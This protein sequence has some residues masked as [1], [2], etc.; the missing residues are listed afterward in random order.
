MCSEPSHRQ[1]AR[2]LPPS[3]AALA[4]ALAS[5]TQHHHGCRHG[6]WEN[7][8]RVPSI[9]SS[10]PTYAA[11]NAR[12][13]AYSDRPLLSLTTLAD[14]SQKA[15]IVRTDGVGFYARPASPFSKNSSRRKDRSCRTACSRLL[16]SLQIAADNS[17][18]TRAT[19]T[20]SHPLLK[21]H[22][23]KKKK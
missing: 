19:L 1:G 11:A 15:S 14:G 6:G 10:T 12:G 3:C 20:S 16:A 5:T 9:H 22:A 21:H 17:P 2:W 8:L 7:T 18:E 4:K 13:V 23:R